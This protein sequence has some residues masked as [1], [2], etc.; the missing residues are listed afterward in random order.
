MRHRVLC[1]VTFEFSNRTAGTLKENYITTTVY[2]SE[3]NYIFNIITS[4]SD[5][6]TFTRK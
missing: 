6:I 2:N 4:I 3:Q 1:F 5:Y